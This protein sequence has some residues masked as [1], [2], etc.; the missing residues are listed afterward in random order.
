MGIALTLQQ[1]LDDKHIDYD[2]LKHKRTHS[3]AR[4][5]AREPRARRASRQG[6]WC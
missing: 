1:Y 5:R 4:H 2:V 6:A 3:L